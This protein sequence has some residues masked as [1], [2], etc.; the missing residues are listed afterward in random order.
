MNPQN[1]ATQPEIDALWHNQ[2]TAEHGITACRAALAA[3][4]TRC[5]NHGVARRDCRQH[6]NQEHE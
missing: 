3:A 1:T 5:C 2:T 6:D 4:K